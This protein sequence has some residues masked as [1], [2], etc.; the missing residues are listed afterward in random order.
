MRTDVAPTV[1]QRPSVPDAIHALA[2]MT[3][4]NYVDLFTV[5]AGETTEKSPEQW[6][7]VALEDASPTGRFIVFQV[8]CGLRL[9]TRPSHDRVAG[10]R[11]ADRG[12]NWI[13]LEAAS[14]FM[15]AH[16]VV[17]VEDDQV[18]VALFVRYDRPLGA[19]LWPPISIGHRRAMPG[20]LIHAARRMTGRG[21]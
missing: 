8:L 4:P 16:A 6:A 5:P 15:T 17:L 14:W 12:D 20:L 21:R 9:D 19:L 11:I 2:N 7:R 3:R 18:S 1:V 13:R 10:W